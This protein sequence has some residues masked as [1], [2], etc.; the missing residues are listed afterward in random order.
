MFSHPDSENGFTLL[1]V[2]VAMAVLA[3]AGMALMGTARE[4]MVNTQYLNN[5]RAAYWVAEN[6]MTDLQLARKLPPESWR[7]QTVS[8]ANREWIVRSRSIETVTRG[9]HSLEVEVK[10]NNSSEAPLAQLQSHKYYL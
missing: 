9:F 7:E 10:E 5:K 8:M 1:E 4:G 3:I 2:M 6:A